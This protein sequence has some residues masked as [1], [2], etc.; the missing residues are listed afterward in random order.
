MFNVFGVIK[1][2][3]G[4]PKMCNLHNTFDHSILFPIFTK[5]KRIYL[6]LNCVNNFQMTQYSLY[7]ILTRQYGAV[8]HMKR[9][10]K[11]TSISVSIL[12][13]EASDALKEK[14][15]AHGRVEIPLERGVYLTIRWKRSD[16]WT[17]ADECWEKHEIE[18]S[19]LKP[20]A[21]PNN[22]LY[23]LHDD[24]LY[25][26]FEQCITTD[27]LHL[28]LC[29]LARVCP[30]FQYILQDIFARKYRT[31]SLCLKINTE[32]LPVIEEFYRLFGERMINVRVDNCLSKDVVIG[33]VE[34]YCPYLESFECIVIDQQS[35]QHIQLLAKRVKRLHVHFRWPHVYEV[36]LSATLQHCPNLEVLSIVSSN[37]KL[38]L[39]SV[40]I[41]KLVDL[42]ISKRGSLHPFSDSLRVKQFFQ[43]NDQLKT[44]RIENIHF[45]LCIDDILDSL[46]NLRSLCIQC[47]SADFECRDFDCFGQ[48]N[49]LKVLRIGMDGPYPRRILRAIARYDIALE[50][51]GLE[52]NE[53][54][55]RMVDAVCR[56]KNLECMELKSNC[57]KLDFQ[58]FVQPLSEMEELKVFNIDTAQAAELLDHVNDDVDKVT[59]IFNE[60]DLRR[61]N[62]M[63]NQ[64]EEIRKAAKELGIILNVELVSDSVENETPVSFSVF[65]LFYKSVFSFF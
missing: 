53:F 35:D 34:K 39:P 62:G 5:N 9:D 48:L 60:C 8:M 51:L 27:F 25:D 4:K 54:N 50:T 33:I 49:K 29:E 28:R 30:R 19:L 64:L 47:P 32:P 46:S 15:R 18:Q 42:H 12:K 43:Q 21:A 24:C 26:I 38:T 3:T 44:L 16:S 55:D 22:I 23:A 11:D 45:G 20:P 1:C 65:F 57:S 14:C 41:P 59:F 10:L 6:F 63:D 52:V 31:L 40:K 13:T 7:T 2:T 56:I 36:F 58:R 17:N 37:A 61:V